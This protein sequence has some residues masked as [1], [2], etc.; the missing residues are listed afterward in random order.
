MVL[1]RSETMNSRQC[2]NHVGDEAMNV[3]GTVFEAAHLHE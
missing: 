3:S 2:D 1:E